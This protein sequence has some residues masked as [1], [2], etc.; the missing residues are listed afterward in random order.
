[1]T[2]ENPIPLLDEILTPWRDRIGADF[3][4]YKNHVGRMLNFCFA[5]RDCDEE[6][7]QKLIIAGA[8][9]DIGIWSAGTVDYLPPS[10]A[11][12]ELYLREHGLADWIAEIGLIID[13][14]H[15][16]RPCRGIISPLVEIFRRADLADFSLGIIKGGVPAATVQAAKSAYPN[17]G[18]HRRLLQLAGAWFAKHPLTPPPFMKW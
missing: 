18:F 13:L 9:H 2:I 11:Q 1:M 17:A 10:I 5:L 6:E 15:K 14:H 3:A 16:L 12:A 8:F 7:R 4:G